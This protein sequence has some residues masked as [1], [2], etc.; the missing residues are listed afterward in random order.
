[1]NVA[2]SGELLHRG[3]ASVNKAAP[4]WDDEARRTG[5]PR[6]AS[7]APRAARPMEADDLRRHVRHLLAQALDFRL[8]GGQTRNSRLIWR[9]PR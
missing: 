1:M 5:R 6:C 2:I 4:V 3:E 7:C 8:G 9:I